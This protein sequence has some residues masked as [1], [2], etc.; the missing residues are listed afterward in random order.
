MKCSY[1][2]FVITKYKIKNKSIVNRR[3]KN[4]NNNNYDDNNNN[5]NKDNNNNNNNIGKTRAEC[6]FLTE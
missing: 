2:L 5:N 4:D 1:I 3:K 6:G